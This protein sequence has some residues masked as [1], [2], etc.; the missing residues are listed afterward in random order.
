MKSVKRFLAMLLFAFYFALNFSPFTLPV[1]ALTVYNAYKRV[2]DTQTVFYED[3]ALTIPLF[4]LPYTYYVKILDEEN[5][6][7][8]IMCFGDGNVPAIDG[9]CLTESLFYDGLE[10]VSPYLSITVITQSNTP[11]FLD[12][13][14]TKIEQYIFPN[15]SLCYYGNI[16]NSENKNMFFISYNGKLGYVLEDNVYPFTIPL[17]PNELTFLGKERE[18]GETTEEKNSSDDVLRTIII[19]ALSLTVLLAVIFIF[20][21]K[22][23][24]TV[25]AGYFD[26]NDFE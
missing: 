15:R 21:K 10:V 2:I 26:E 12:T 16:L 9:Y 7:S 11:L 20:S 6:V 19:C 3:K 24:P 18:G 22:E 23:K 1:S 4:Y 14:S 17:H 8:H 13:L 25:S 5:G